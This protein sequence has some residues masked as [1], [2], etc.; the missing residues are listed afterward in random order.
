MESTVSRIGF[1]RR[2]LIVNGIKKQIGLEIQD[3][4]F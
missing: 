1:G 2:V 4:D 3:S